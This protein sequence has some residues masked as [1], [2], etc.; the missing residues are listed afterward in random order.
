[1]GTACCSSGHTVWWQPHQ[2]AI[3]GPRGHWQEG[4]GGKVPPSRLLPAQGSS[5]PQQGPAAVQQG[6]PRLLRPQCHSTG[7]EPSRLLVVA[8]PPPGTQAEPQ[9]THSTSGPQAP[10]LCKEGGPD[11]PCDLHSPKVTEATI[12]SYP[13]VYTDLIPCP[14]PHPLPSLG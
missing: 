8:L 14:H 10:H 1:M 5:G 4:P 9:A 2:S 13:A 7:S 11:G 12:S 3:Q 6:P